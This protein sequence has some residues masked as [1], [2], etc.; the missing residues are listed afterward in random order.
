MQRASIARVAAELLLGRMLAR[1]EDLCVNSRDTSRIARFVPRVQPS[2]SSA[3]R[4]FS[5]KANR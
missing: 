2:R 4:T 3:T 5:A 1:I